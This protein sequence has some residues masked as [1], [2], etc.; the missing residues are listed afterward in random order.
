M[1]GRASEP[2]GQVEDI[3]MDVPSGRV[4]YVIVK[5]GD[6]SVPQDTRYVVPPSLVTVDSA[7]RTAMLNSDQAHF[8]AGPHFE[9]K[10][11]GD[12]TRPELVTA[13]HQH[14]GIQATSGQ[15]DL[16]RQ[17]ART[18]LDT[19]AS[20]LTDDEITK[21]VMTEVTHNSSVVMGRDLKITTVNGKVTLTGQPRNEKQRQQIVTAAER[22]VGAGNVNDQTGSR[23]R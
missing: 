4:A 13:V 6:A 15:T 9:A 20:P 17:P 7:K 21:A 2:L 11:L 5:A 19:T 12:L 1:I 10:F 8:I 3:A 16:T 14:Y 23:G 18:R 22:V